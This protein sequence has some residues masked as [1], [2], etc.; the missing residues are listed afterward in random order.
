MV[1]ECYLCVGHR[2]LSILGSSLGGQANDSVVFVGTKAC[3]TLQW[4]STNITC[5]LPVLPPGLYDVFV[6]VRNNGYPQ[7]RYSYGDLEMFFVFFCVCGYTVRNGLGV[8]T[9]TLSF[10]FFEVNKDLT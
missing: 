6:Q 3:V 10:F 8:I 9:R 5:A 7:I 4:T 1:Y 2:I